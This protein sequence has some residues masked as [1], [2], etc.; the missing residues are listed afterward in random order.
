MIIKF[1]N[2]IKSEINE[3]FPKEHKGN[4]KYNLTKEQIYPEGNFLK[5]SL[6]QNIQKNFEKSNFKLQSN[7]I[8]IGTCFAE[9]FS[10]FLLKKSHNYKILEPNT[11]N[12]VVNWGRVY[13]VSNLRQLIDYSFESKF[14]IFSEIG[15]KGYFDPLRDYSCGS[16][17][18]K[19]ELISSIK[20]HRKLSKEVLSK[21]NFI[22]I[23]LG[24]TEAWID[25]Q[26]NFTWGSAPIWCEDFLA[27]RKKYIKKNFELEEITG[28]LRYVISKIKT[29]NPNIKIF[30]TLSPVP[31]QATFFNE[32]VILSS[33][34]GKAKL[35]LS[36][37][38]ILSDFKDVFYI[39]SYEN[40]IQDNKNFKVDKRHV[41]RTKV[42]EIFSVF[43]GC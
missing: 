3:F 9:E 37:E 42:K 16:F 36:I 17:K 2:R 27:E 19:A 30:L 28:D 7:V 41:K 8:S 24:Q 15:I 35:R 21:S 18:T 20:N 26:N 12:F 31:S 40:V 6:N 1:F 14:K 34:I 29:H 32:N 13:T 4:E 10:Y 25:K 43:R 38:N 11:F 22:F 23:T 39:P 5:A 33:S